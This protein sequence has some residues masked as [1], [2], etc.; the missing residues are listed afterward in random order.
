MLTGDLPYS[1]ENVYARSFTY[2]GFGV[3]PVNESIT[4]LFRREDECITLSRLSMVY[5]DYM[6]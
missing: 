5:I 4:K 3:G 2:L 1:K 6:G